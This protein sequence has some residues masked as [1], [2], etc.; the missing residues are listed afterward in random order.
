MWSR[1]RNTEPIG[2]SKS[3]VRQNQSTEDSESLSLSLSLS[4]VISRAVLLDTE[5]DMLVSG[6]DSDQP[7]RTSLSTPNIVHRSLSDLV[8]R[9]R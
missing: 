6:A 1:T 3:Q 5:L 8:L 7:A 9:T 2:L 4:L